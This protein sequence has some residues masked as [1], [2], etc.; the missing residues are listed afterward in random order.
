MGKLK[1][2]AGQKFGML[3]VVSWTGN[4]YWNCICDCGNETQARGNALRSGLRVSCGC[5]NKGW[6][7]TPFTQEKFLEQSHAAHGV[8]Y[9]Y[10]NAVYKTS[11]EKVSII[12][13]KHGPFD[14]LAHTHVAGGGCAACAVE[15][16]AKARTMPQQEFLEKAEKV[17]GEKYDYS[18]VDYRN[19]KVSVTIGCKSCGNVFQQTPNSHLRGSGC[20]PCGYKA[21]TLKLRHDTERFTEAA[22]RVHGTAFDYSHAE[23]ETTHKKVKIICRTCNNSFMQTPMKHLQGRGCHF[24]QKTGFSTG[25]A[26]ILYVLK[27]GDLTKVGITN[28]TAAARAKFVSE[29]SGHSFEVLRSYTFDSGL[30]CLN[31][32][33]ALLRKLRQVYKNPES[34]FNGRSECFFEVNLASLYEDIEGL[35]KELND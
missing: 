7:H 3:T 14:Q 33:T 1:G 23:Y 11:Q 21:A 24:C 35:M 28:K 8:R 9:D 6:E 10:S 25:K 16:S 27:A 4:R 20:D 29:S 26:G 12:C 13:H 5:F 18:K 19:S 15:E 32:E 17:H 30:D 31:V 22:N 34:K 2:I